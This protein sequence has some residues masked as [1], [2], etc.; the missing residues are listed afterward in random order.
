M[1]CFGVYEDGDFPSVGGTGEEQ[2]ASYEDTITPLMNALVKFRDEVK[3]NAD[4][5][6]KTLF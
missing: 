5:G 2:G 3:L 4:H 1:K 6:G